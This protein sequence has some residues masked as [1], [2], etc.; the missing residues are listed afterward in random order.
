MAKSTRQDRGFKLAEV[1]LIAARSVSLCV[2][3]CGRKRTGSEYRSDIL[4]LSSLIKPQL[5]LLEPEEADRLVSLRL[6]I[7]LTIYMT[8][9][10]T[11][12]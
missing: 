3:V 12:G 10:I 1:S 11:C 6:Q 9:T 2:F 7:A 4:T 8:L 5:S